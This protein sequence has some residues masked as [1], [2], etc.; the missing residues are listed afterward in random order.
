ATTTYSLTVTRNAEFDAEPNDLVTT[1]QP[2]RTTQMAGNQT[3]LG[4]IDSA[5]TDY[6]A[7]SATGGVALNFSTLT[8]GDGAGEPVN[9]LNPR[10]QI[11]NASSVLVA[12]DDNS[13]PDGRNA[14]LTYTPPTTGTYY[15]AVSSTT[16]TSTAGDYTLTV[17]N[18]VPTAAA[19]NVSNSNLAAVVKT[20]PTTVTLTF[21]SSI[22]L[23][24]L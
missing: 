21:N 12:S 11:Y 8:P 20:A 17:Q 10:L 6:Y 14:Q 23:P 1:A 24:T 19:F 15:I 2:I 4:H 16:V 3:V 7:I 22:L 5:N 9:T 18:A 13:A